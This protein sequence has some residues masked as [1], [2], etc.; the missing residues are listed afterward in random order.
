[1]VHHWCRYVNGV[2]Y[3]IRGLMLGLEASTYGGRRRTTCATADRRR[4]ADSG[5]RSRHRQDQERAAVGYAMIGPPAVLIHQQCYF[6]IRRIA[7]VSGL[8]RICS[9]FAASCRPMPMED[10]TVSTIGQSG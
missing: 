6:A 2:V 10:S 7:K 4:H 8:V 9:T 3:G 1:M 5:A